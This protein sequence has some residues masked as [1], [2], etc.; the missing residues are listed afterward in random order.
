MAKTC[1]YSQY[2][3]YVSN[4]GGVTWERVNEFH[5][6]RLL[7][8]NSMDCGGSIAE[9]KWVDITPVSGDQTTYWCDDCPEVPEEEKAYTLVYYG[10]NRYS[11]TIGCNEIASTINSANTKNTGYDIGD[12]TDVNVSE[13]CITKIG[14]GA[15]SGATQLSGLTL[16]SR[17]IQVAQN[18]FNSCSSLTGIILPNTIRDIGKQAF[19]NCTHL[20]TITIMATNPPSL[21][22]DALKRTLAITTSGSIYV[23]SSAVNTYKSASGW[24]NYSDNIRAIP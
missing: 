3:K 5:R 12:L 20:R 19:Y 13:N 9:Y 23:P 14:F 18:A 1:K 22:T 8:A 21:G 10:D 15:F 4:D 2:Q 24:S 11:V 17:I 6:G 16:N 7:E